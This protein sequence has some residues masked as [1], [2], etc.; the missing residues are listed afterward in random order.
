MLTVCL[1]G[2]SMRTARPEWGSSG[3]VPD[4]RRQARRAEMK[5]CSLRSTLDVRSTDRRP[6]PHDPTPRRELP[7]VA[8]SGAGTWR[9]DERWQVVVTTADAEGVIVDRRV[10]RR[11][12]DSAEIAS[13]NLATGTTLSV[14]AGFAN[15]K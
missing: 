13:V 5:P 6:Q 8:V 2:G 14:D 12:P 1:L 15:K 9:I 11:P 7:V 4:R 3:D 10:H